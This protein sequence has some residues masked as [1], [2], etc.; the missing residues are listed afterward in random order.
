MKKIA[1]TLLLALLA[2]P[3]APLRAQ[4]LSNPRRGVPQGNDAY[5]PLA[6]S[7]ILATADAAPAALPFPK[8]GR[9]VTI[10][11]W[12][13]LGVSA[14]L[15]IYGFTLN[16]DANDTFSQLET[17]CKD[18]PENCRSRNP[19]GTYSDPLLEALYQESLDKDNTARSF[20]IA[21]QVF[22]GISVVLF[23]VDFQKDDGPGN[24][25]YD[26]DEEKSPLRLEALPGEIA[27]RYYLR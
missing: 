3:A 19:D 23:I 6:S 14:G 5:F 10:T 13:T 25:P 24:V 18:D 1:A 16:S 2:T 26:P 7:Q 22:F 4:G 27:I 17:L 15:G 11:K 20:L 21:S 8:H 12:A 9:W